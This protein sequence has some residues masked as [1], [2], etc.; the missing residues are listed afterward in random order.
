MLQ[1][2]RKL[3]L[4]L[5][6]AAFASCTSLPKPKQTYYSFPKDAYIQAPKRPMQ[7]MGSVKS[8]ADYPSLDATHEEQELCRNYFNKAVGDMV[9]MAKERGADAVVDV[10]SIV[11]MEDSRVETYPKP[12]CADDGESG[13]VLVHGIAVK[14]KTATDPSSPFAIPAGQQPKPRTQDRIKPRP[15]PPPVTRPVSPTDPIVRE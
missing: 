8:R 3:G 4:A 1:S 14:W 9:R 15:S 11:V 10:K 5:L 13:Q 7:T 6:L 2:S 12:E